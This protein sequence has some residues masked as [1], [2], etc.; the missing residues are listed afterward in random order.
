MRALQAAAIL[1]ALALVGG[2]TIRSLGAG[3]PL[4]HVAD[5]WVAG[6]LL[7][8]AAWLTGRPGQ[9]ARRGVAAIWGAVAAMTLISFLAKLVDPA[10][11]APGNLPPALLT[12]LVGTA[13]FIALAALV[14]SLLLPVPEDRP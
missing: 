10:G 6:V 3:R 9:V 1:L 8:F 14:A 7:L 12:A 5:D 4:L 2:E 13:F 11:M